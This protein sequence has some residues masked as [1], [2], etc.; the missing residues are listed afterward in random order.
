M[1]RFKSVSY[2]TEK[3][4]ELS[5]LG[6]GK[7][8]LEL[9]LGGQKIAFYGRANFDPQTI[10]GE[11]RKISEWEK[12]KHSPA[13]LKD[14]LEY[15][16]EEDAR[17][18]K[19]RNSE[20]YL[21]SIENLNPREYINFLNDFLNSDLGE[22]IL[23]RSEIDSWEDIRELSPRQAMLLCSNTVIK[24]RNYDCSEITQRHRK[25]D[26]LT[27][28]DIF[29]H[30]SKNRDQ[31]LGVC[32]NYTDMTKILFL[33]IKKFQV[34]ETSRLNNTFCE[35][36][37]G[38]TPFDM[39]EEYKTRGHKWNRFMTFT[40]EGVAECFIDT[41]TQGIDKPTTPEEG[42]FIGFQLKESTIDSISEAIFKENLETSHNLS[43][44]SI[45]NIEN[46]Y[47]YYKGASSA[48]YKIV[49]KDPKYKEK[50]RMKDIFM[51]VLVKNNI[52]SK[53]LHQNGRMA[54]EDFAKVKRVC[55]RAITSGR[56][57]ENLRNHL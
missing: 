30:L 53:I 51:H 4:L 15:R 48:I 11:A 41:T 54:E 46:L 2:E 29:N 32:R 6:S 47:K 17:I 52:Y 25:A 13:N 34:P 55:K 20:T 5:N 38:Y 9:S 14:D 18:N 7:K 36:T 37:S 3:S 27:A 22:G 35:A 57:R 49:Q 45:K 24:L 21:K 40:D 26:S 10:K 42:L 8:S 28:L 43:E 19:D 16:S 31:P 56:M 12:F 50:Q 33:S 1:E 44:E 23:E 39:T